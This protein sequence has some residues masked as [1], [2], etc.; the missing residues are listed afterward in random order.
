MTSILPM[1]KVVNNWIEINLLSQ[2]SNHAT[3]LENVLYNIHIYTAFHNQWHQLCAGQMVFICTIFLC[4]CHRQN[5][6]FLCVKYQ[7]IFSL[8]L[9]LS[10]S[11][12]LSISYLSSP[13]ISLSPFLPQSLSLSS[14]SFFLFHTHTHTIRKTSTGPSILAESSKKFL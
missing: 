9:S 8:S 13:S 2:D 11:I 6:F 10:I 14:L 12:S 5:T 3:W 4:N 7:N 1:R